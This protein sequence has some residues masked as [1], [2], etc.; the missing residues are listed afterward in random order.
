MKDKGS[1]KNAE[2]QEINK[3]GRTVATEELQDLVR[4]RVLRNVGTT[5]RSANYILERS[6]D[7]RPLNDRNDH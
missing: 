4:R 6:E 5:G 1:I 7:E 2:Y 3:V